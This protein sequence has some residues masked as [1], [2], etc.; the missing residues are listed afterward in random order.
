MD[1]VSVDLVLESCQR[2]S[3]VEPVMDFFG[4]FTRYNVIFSQK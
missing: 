3:N 1:F 2:A 4:T